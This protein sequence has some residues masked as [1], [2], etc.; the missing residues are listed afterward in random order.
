[1][2]R[3]RP[4][5]NNPPDFHDIMM[6]DALEDIEC[7]FCSP[8]VTDWGVTDDNCLHPSDAGEDYCAKCGPPLSQFSDAFGEVSEDPSETDHDESD[9]SKYLGLRFC[10]N[11]PYRQVDVMK[12]KIC[13]P[14]RNEKLSIMSH[15]HSKHRDSFHSHTLSEILLLQLFA[16]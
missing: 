4:G 15:R 13:L 8:T 5:P 6:G 1:M 11:S 10:K 16:H 7:T 12:S 3:R 9:V 2:H 14:C